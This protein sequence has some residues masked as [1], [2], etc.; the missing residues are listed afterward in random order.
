MRKW[1]ACLV[2]SLL[3]SSQRLRSKK[4]KASGWLEEEEEGREER[5]ASR[6]FSRELKGTKWTLLPSSNRIVCKNNI[7]KL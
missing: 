5:V 3:I 4:K 6:L 1:T 7:Y 2:T